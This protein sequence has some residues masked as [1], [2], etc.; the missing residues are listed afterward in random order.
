MLHGKIKDLKGTVDFTRDTEI[1]II[2]MMEEVD[3]LRKK[4]NMPAKYFYE[5]KVG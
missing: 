3:E 1:R 5:K 2:H 4:L